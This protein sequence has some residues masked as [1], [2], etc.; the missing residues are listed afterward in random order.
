MELQSFRRPLSQFALYQ[1]D[2]LWP[3][4]WPWPHDLHIRT[5]P[6]SLEDIRTN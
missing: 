1:Q 5:W 3:W 2:L 4:P 6:V